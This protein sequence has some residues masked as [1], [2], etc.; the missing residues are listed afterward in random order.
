MI[1]KTWQSEPCHILGGGPSLDIGR[2]YKGRIIAINAAILDRPDA[3]V[4]FLSDTRFLKWGKNLDAVRD[5]KGLKFMRCSKEAYD[6][7]G[8]PDIGLTFL[9]RA[10]KGQYISNDPQRLAGL[11]SGGSAINLAYLLG[12]GEIFLHGFDMRFIG[13]KA[14]YH[15]RHQVKVQENIYAVYRRAIEKMATQITVPVYNCTRGS[16]L[17]CFP[18]REDM[19]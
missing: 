8:L 16:A 9:L 6:N 15:D 7:A 18:F 3:D 4:A 13:G 12:A 5:F 10:R 2:E 1:P 19:F 17:K 11:C 14:N